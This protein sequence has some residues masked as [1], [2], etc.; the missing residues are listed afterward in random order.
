MKRFTLAIT[1]VLFIP[2]VSL[3]A[4]F[5]DVP[6][7]HENATAIYDLQRRG[8]VQG[9]DDG[10]FAPDRHLNRAELLTLIYRANGKETRSIYHGCAK[11]VP[12]EAWFSTVVCTAMHNK[13][14]QGYP[15][16]T[17]RPQQIVNIV[18]ALKMVLNGMEFTIPDLTQ[19]D[20]L[21][22]DFIG[23][24]TS[25]AW[26]APYLH[27][28]IALG[29]LPASFTENNTFNASESLTRASAAEILYRALNTEDNFLE[30]DDDDEED[31]V[32]S[33]S[34]PPSNNSNNNPPPTSSGE[35]LPIY[36]TGETGERGA[37]AFF[38]E[39]S[40]NT[41]V[42][43]EARNLTSASTGLKC[44]LYLLGENGFSN[45]FFI[46]Y[47]EGG[48]CFINGSLRAGSYQIE[49][50][51]PSE[52]ADYS[53]DVD[54]GLGDGNDGFVDAVTLKVSRPRTDTLSEGD[55]EDWYHFSVN[56]RE[57]H[58]V[59]VN[60]VDDLSCMLFPADN[61]DLSSFSIPKCGNTEE[62]DPGD[63]YVS[64]KKKKNAT[65]TQTYTVELR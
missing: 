58:R 20:R 65:E 36:K 22:I 6:S 63:W 59:K 38:F 28:S 54:Y 45:E 44:Y 55:Y 26:Y 16:R 31:E 8:I 18:E 57:A 10:T 48:G 9:N 24:I 42:K 37:S 19:E 62:Y 21:S 2:S 15:D 51:S 41:R 1:A 53:L 3:A 46:G 64:V 60:S 5:P 27:R 33:P 17:F 23:D 25:S 35:D 52:G 50:R 32:P 39:I 29:L 13:F 11:D 14:V 4:S 43:V 7:E 40:T 56:S 30:D 47:E 49:I 34:S 12:S 61:V